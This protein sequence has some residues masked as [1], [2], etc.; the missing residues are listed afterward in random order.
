M[1]AFTMQFRKV[2]QEAGTPAIRK[3]KIDLAEK[4][5]IPFTDVKKKS[6]AGDVKSIKDFIT[7]EKKA[8]TSSE[9]EFQRLLDQTGGKVRILK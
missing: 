9:E 6:V 4:R 7:N 3:L 5:A 8:F 2:L 1:S